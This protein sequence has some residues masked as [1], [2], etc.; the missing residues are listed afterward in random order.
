MSTSNTP[1]ETN[2][3]SNPPF[4]LAYPDYYLK[5]KCLKDYYNTTIVCSSLEGAEGFIQGV[6]FTNDSA[7]SVIGYGF[8][9]NT[10]TV[11]LLDK[12]RW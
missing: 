8:F 1:Q 11:F 2:L 9:D 4:K 5:E 3:I 12:D 10:W 7:L 6:E